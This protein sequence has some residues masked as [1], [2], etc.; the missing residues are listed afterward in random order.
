MR[1]WEVLGLFA[2]L[3]IDLTV[4]IALLANDPDIRRDYYEARLDFMIWLA[5]SIMR[6]R[7]RG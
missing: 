6:E 7:H 1:F 2:F 5:T 3:W 4:L